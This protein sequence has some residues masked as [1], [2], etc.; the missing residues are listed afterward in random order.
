MKAIGI[1][2]ITVD[3]LFLFASCTRQD[4]AGGTMETENSVAVRVLDS[5]GK[6]SAGIAAH[7]RPVWYLGEQKN[8]MTAEEAHQ[9]GIRNIVSDKNGWL[10]CDS[11]PSGR[12]RIE[13]GNTTLAAATEFEYQR[14]ED[15]ETLTPLALARTGILQGSIKLPVDVKSV[16]L[17]V[18]GSDLKTRT[19]SKGNF[20][21]AGVPSGVVR[22]VA[23]STAS[24]TML[25]ED[26]AQVRPGI[27][28]RLGQ[29]AVPTVA[30][31]DLL[32]WRYSSKIRVD[33]LVRDWMLPLSDTAM[34]TFKL[35]SPNFDFSLAVA[36]GRDFRVTDVLDRPLPFER[37]LWD[38]KVGKAFIRVAVPSYLIYPGATIT[39]RWGHANSIQP[40]TTGLWAG[41][42]DSVKQYL[43]KILVGDF[44]R[45]DSRTDLPNFLP[46]IAWYVRASD[47][48][49]TMSP[50]PF[51]DIVSGFQPAGLGRE[52][53]ALHI[54]YKLSDPFVKWVM[55]GT[56]IGAG[57]ALDFS[58][59]DSI[60]LYARGT[61]KFSFAFDNLNGEG[62]K[63]ILQLPLDSV[64]KKYV[65]LPS[66]FDPENLKTEVRSWSSVQDSITNMTIFASQGND[67]WLDKIQLFGVGVEDFRQ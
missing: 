36:D 45:T 27:T 65:I 35:L 56:A 54:S 31:E 22:V 21:L 4:T 13:V 3:I 47:S 6:P 52:G 59:L 41:I 10:H 32:T 2:F 64:W 11:L 34:L 38:S 26:L 55:L 46:A 67:I 43:T 49:V 53:K 37:V 57:A 20:E 44:E 8:A 51:T 60:V 33:S 30:N 58:S 50:A 40:D 24:A 9:A 19:D 16:L 42:P 15:Q 25:G 14:S 12:Y 18:Y 1:L 62:V 7:V 28:S 17:Q 23:T 63:C 39:L 48:S 5:L 29:V 61:G 66:N